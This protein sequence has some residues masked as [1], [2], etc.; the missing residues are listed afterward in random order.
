MKRKKLTKK[1]NKRLF[2]STA[3]KTKPVNLK[4][5][6]MRGGIRM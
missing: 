1:G 2:K 5:D 4:P 6:V 3:L